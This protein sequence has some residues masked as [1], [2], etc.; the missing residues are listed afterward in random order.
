MS[1]D[2]IYITSGIT[3]VSRQRLPCYQGSGKLV[4]RGLCCCVQPRQAGG[5]AFAGSIVSTGLQHSQTKEPSNAAVKV[6]EIGAAH[7]RVR[8]Q[9]SLSSHSPY[10]CLRKPLAVGLGACLHRLILL[11]P[12]HS[13]SMADILDSVLSHGIIQLVCL[14]RQLPSIG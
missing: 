11:P 1:T 2:L 6:V 9:S 8:P 4:A 10:N 13:L 12:H 3:I 14:Q 7:D 5:Y